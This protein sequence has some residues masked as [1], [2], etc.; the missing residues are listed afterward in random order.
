MNHATA[1]ELLLW[2]GARELA[3]VAVPEDHPPVT[4]ELMRRTIAQENRDDCTPEE[5]AA[6]DAGMTA[7]Q[8]ALSDATRLVESHLALRHALPLSAGQVAQSPLPRICGA[9][10][11][12][13]L[14]HDRAPDAVNAGYTQAM[15]WLQDL[16]QGRTGIVG[17]AV[18]GAGA[19]ACDA[20][21]RVFDHQTLRGFA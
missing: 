16:A 2:F 6:A 8:R 20:A 12:R 21:L 17:G 7:I 18:I 3:Q 4:P 5:I 9:I 10:A 19:P 13:L 14:H 15:T 11:R 1:M